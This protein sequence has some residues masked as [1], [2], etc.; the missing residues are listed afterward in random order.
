MSTSN[1]SRIVSELSICNLCFQH[2]IMNRGGA[3]ILTFLGEDRRP[4]RYFCSTEHLEDFLEDYHANCIKLG[5]YLMAS[6]KIQS[7]RK[8]RFARPSQRKGGADSYEMEL[9]GYG[10]EVDL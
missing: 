7:E 9:P 1:H 8:Y 2:R 6:R 3:L 5:H 10:T 4:S